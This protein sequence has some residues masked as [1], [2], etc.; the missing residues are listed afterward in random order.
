MRRP[1]LM[2]YGSD[3]QPRLLP[4]LEYGVEETPDATEDSSQSNDAEGAEAAEDKE[5]VVNS[6]DYDT[7]LDGEGQSHVTLVQCSIKG[8]WGCCSTRFRCFGGPQ[9]GSK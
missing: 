3:H 4:L 1:T 6:D 2:T 9:L 8:C 7:D 5:S